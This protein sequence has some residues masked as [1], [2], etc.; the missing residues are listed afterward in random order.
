[1][2]E[3]AIALSKNAKVLIM[4]E[5]TAALSRKETEILFKIIAD[6]K[7]QGIGIIYISHKLEEVKQIGDRIT[8]LRDGLTVATVPA[9]AADLQ[10]IIGLMIGKELVQGR[11]QQADAAVAQAIPCCRWRA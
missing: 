5:P 6:I 1:M 8:V 3:I 11:Q 9:R 10:Q 2:L 4:D 7:A